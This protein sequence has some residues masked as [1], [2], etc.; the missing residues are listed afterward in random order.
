MQKL[1]VVLGLVIL[2]LV[3]ILSFASAEVNCPEENEN[4]TATYFPHETECGKF[5]ECHN[6]EAAL[7]DCAPGSYWDA[8]LNVCNTDV[9]C[10]DLLTS[11]APP[12]TT[13]EDTDD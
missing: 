13:A 6:G 10:G 8:R 2:G 7:L 4:S 5:Y 12:P 3:A 9:N 11:T 1:I